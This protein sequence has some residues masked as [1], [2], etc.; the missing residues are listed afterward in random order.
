MY[1]HPAPVFNVCTSTR[2]SPLHTFL[3]LL[4]LVLNRFDDLLSLRAQNKKPL[5]FWAES[6]FSASRFARS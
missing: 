4:N 3:Q 2:T 6:S 1:P 5:P